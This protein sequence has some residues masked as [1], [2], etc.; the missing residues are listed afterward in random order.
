MRLYLRM[1][2]LGGEADERVGGAPDLEGSREADDG[3]QGPSERHEDN[4]EGVDTDARC[5]AESYGA[6]LER[7]LRAV[8]GDA[9]NNAGHTAQAEA[10]HADHAEDRDTQAREG[11]S[12]MKLT[13]TR[14]WMW[15]E[16][17]PTV[18]EP[19]AAA[20]PGTANCTASRRSAPRGAKAGKGGAMRRRRVEMERPACWDAEK[21]ACW[22]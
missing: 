5:A 7:D 16:T 9:N 21:E 18:A 4:E 17:A 14:R 11:T 19:V 12:L 15:V 8:D 10:G 1:V 20:T 3:A 6:A 13:L 2:R 22:A